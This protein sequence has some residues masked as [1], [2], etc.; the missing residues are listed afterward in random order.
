M[1]TSFFHTS[2]E[3]TSSSS[4]L[5]REEPTENG[6]PPAR[7]DVAGERR[8]VAG[9]LARLVRGVFLRARIAKDVAERSRKRQRALLAMQDRRE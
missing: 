9:L 4:R 7:L 1:P 6:L 8:D 2:G 3:A 5:P